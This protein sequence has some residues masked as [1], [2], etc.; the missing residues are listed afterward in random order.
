MGLAELENRVK[1]LQSSSSHVSCTVG[2]EVSIQEQVAVSFLPPIGATSR[3][4]T[5][6][7]ED[8]NHSNLAVGRDNNQSNNR[9]KR[10]SSGNCS[11]CLLNGDIRTDHR[12]N[13]P[14]C[15]YFKSI[16]KI[17]LS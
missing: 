13:S 16:K 1:E 7:F 4:T 2:E 9:P 5:A 6:L 8:K 11:V 3:A 12:G 17:K 15:P 10:A 14:N